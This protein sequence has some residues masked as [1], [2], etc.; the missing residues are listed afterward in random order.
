MKK[1]ERCFIPMLICM[2]VLLCFSAAVSEA[3]QPAVMLPVGELS[4]QTH[5][6]SNAN[7]LYQIPIQSET[8]MV[9]FCIE[10]AADHQ[11]CQLTICDEQGQPLAACSCPAGE[12]LRLSFRVEANHSYNV[13]ITCETPGCTAGYRF[14]W[15]DGM[16]QEA[17]ETG[18]AICMT[19]S[20]PGVYQPGILHSDRFILR[21]N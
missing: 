15:C 9:F 2:L 8:R 16:H 1:H 13:H 18:C 11:R 4:M 6:A 14:G 20:D 5:V 12:A 21:K 17:A 10:A 7:A 3:W 19:P